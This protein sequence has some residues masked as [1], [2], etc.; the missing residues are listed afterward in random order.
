[1]ETLTSLFSTAAGVTGWIGTA[2]AV[3]L[4]PALAYLF[5]PR[6]L[7]A[8]NDVAAVVTARHWPNIFNKDKIVARNGAQL[9]TK[10]GSSSESSVPLN[11]FKVEI[12]RKGKDEALT[13]S[14]KVKVEVTAEFFVRVENSD[15]GIITALQSLGG[16]IGQEQITEYCTPKFDAALR[17]AASQMDI[18]KIQTD[19]AHFREMVT[20]ALDSLKADGLELTD[21]SLRQLNQSPLEHFDKNNYFDAQ[22]LKIVT[23]TIQDSRKIVNDSEQNATTLIQERNKD[24]EIKRLAIAELQ[25]KATL[26]QGQ[27]VKQMQ[28]E[29]AR[30]IA[31]VTA[32]NERKSRMAQIVAEQQV[33]VAEQEKMRAI[34]IAQAERE[35]TAGSAEVDKKIVLH[36]K[37]GEE[38]DAETAANQR[39]ALAAAAEASV[40][41]ARQVAEAD[42]AKQIQVIEAE[43]EAEKEAAAGRIAAQNRVFIAEQ[44]KL[45]ALAEAEAIRTNAQ[46]AKDAAALEAQGAYEKAFQILKA[47]AD[48]KAAE[49]VAQAA[50]NEAVNKL[51]PEARQYLVDMA[52]VEITPEA[53]REAMKP[54]EKIGNIS[55]TSMNG[56][57]GGMFGGAAGVDADG[58]AVAGPASGGMMGEIVQAMLYAEAAKPMLAR[59]LE[60][61]GGDKKIAD[62]L[63]GASSAFAASVVPADTVVV[64]EAQEQNNAQPAPAAAAPVLKR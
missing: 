5:W 36:A 59:A 50:L 34:A 32:D 52:R 10:W 44:G 24:E 14:D 22:G 4:P 16:K 56:G 30:T 39:R 1:M 17:A 3:V 53:I 47:Q 63:P 61:F 57:L 7:K 49:A 2:A 26:D 55:V 40:A 21:V 11:T 60:Q 9:Y 45:E 48:G 42:R 27:R 54:V 51:S 8:E 46:A 28:A 58:K 62:N 31:E 37:A 29:Q 6:Q 43:A 23:Q 33:G 12:I 38:A 15:E 19:R 20:K 35:K 13:L 25:Q 41:T 64:P 18:E